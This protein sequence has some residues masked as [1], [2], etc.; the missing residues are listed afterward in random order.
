MMQ[1]R[2]RWM[3]WTAL[4]GVLALTGQ[5]NWLGTD[6]QPVNNL[7]EWLDAQFANRF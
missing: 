2:V 4:V 6:V 7:R 3:L 5:L 1:A